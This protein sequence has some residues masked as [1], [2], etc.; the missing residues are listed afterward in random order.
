MSG[1]ITG[2]AGHQSH[3]LPESQPQ[4]SGKAT[5]SSH[6]YRKVSPLEAKPT[7]GLHSS[8]MSPQANASRG[9]KK[10]D[11]SGLKVIIQ[12]AD[13]VGELARL[14]GKITSLKPERQAA[15]SESYSHKME[16]LISS[17]L[18]EAQSPSE[19]LSL[20]NAISDHLSNPRARRRLH[21]SLFTDHLRG[22]KES[23]INQCN[24]PDQRADLE[25]LL[26]SLLEKSTLKAHHKEIESLLEHLADLPDIQ[27]DTM[28]EVYR[29]YQQQ[30]E[31][32]HA[33]DTL[34]MTEPEHSP[35][36]NM[37]RIQ[38]QNQ[39][40]YPFTH[41]LEHLKELTY[42]DP[43]CRSALK[44]MEQCSAKASDS[45]PDD[46]NLSLLRDLQKW[47]DTVVENPKAH[48]NLQAKLLDASVEILDNQLVHTRK[49]GAKL[50]VRDQFEKILQDSTLPLDETLPI[51]QDAC[52]LVSQH[53]GKPAPSWHQEFTELQSGHGSLLTFASLLDSASNG[54]EQQDLLTAFVEDK[55]SSYN[56]LQAV[57]AE[58]EERDEPDSIIDLS[59]LWGLADRETEHLKAL[60]GWTLE[61]IQQC[62]QW[63]NA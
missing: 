33:E 54:T 47:I 35:S 55:M 42:P 31:Q 4:E 24:D 16:Q 38:M 19:L 3:H 2:P 27:D 21:Q 22:Q 12:K 57:R 30:V 60:N 39:A 34:E 48:S 40:T 14:K 29:V 18:S 15:L 45:N 37:A 52:Q 20:S 17:E 62:E 59:E 43:F 6:Q 13:S 1:D 25:Q 61:Q 41:T 5:E 58:I 50:D 51:Y 44:F 23:L 10:S 49:A 32:E 28:D 11:V 26:E 36:Y 56:Q 9:K 46:L 7:D 8:S 53:S 63:L